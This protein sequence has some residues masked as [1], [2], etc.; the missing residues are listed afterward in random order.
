MAPRLY[1]VLLCMLL[2]LAEADEWEFLRGNYLT[3]YLG[4][5]PRCKSAPKPYVRGGRTKPIRGQIYRGSNNFRRKGVIE[6]AHLP[7]IT[8]PCRALGNSNLGAHFLSKFGGPLM[9]LSVEIPH[10]VVVRLVKIKALCELVKFLPIFPLEA[11]STGEVDRA[12]EDI[13]LSYSHTY[14]GPI[15]S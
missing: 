10:Y 5:G 3:P 8:R 9:G 12:K 1:A 4:L 6:H 14:E 13:C 11:P 2:V 7:L 15:V